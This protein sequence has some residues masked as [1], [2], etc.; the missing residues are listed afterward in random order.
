MVNS[1]TGF[2]ALK[3]SID[4]ARWAWEVRSVNARGLDLRLRLPEGMDDL[5]ATV[6][7]AFSAALTRGNV[8]VNLRL[9]SDAATGVTALD[10]AQLDRVLKAL[11]TV[12]TMA[13]DQELHLT[14]ST[15]ADILALRGVLETSDN[16]DQ[17][18]QELSTAIKTQLPDLVVDFVAA[19][20]AEGAAL[21]GVLNQRLAQVTE[22]V[23]MAKPAA[24][25]RQKTVAKS[26]RRNLETL[27]ENT[28]GLD[29]GRI[30]QELAMLAVKADV[31]EELDRLEAHIVA[32]DELLNSDGAIGRKFDFLMQEFNREANTLCSKSGSPEL[33]SIGLDLKTV[34]DQMRE[35]VQNVE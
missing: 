28:D 8:S 3:G 17:N 2:A 6:R 12:E 5:E 24:V 14:A 22:L 11:K 20:A 32:A 19:R 31:T 30:A 29:E 34:I 23:S 27:L 26:L 33:T 15:G 35:Q 21:R 1:M 18:Q 25:E 9:H 4:G 16:R 7:K 10:E 13:G